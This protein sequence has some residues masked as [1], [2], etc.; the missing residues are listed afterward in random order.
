MTVVAVARWQVPIR[1][2]RE[3]PNRRPINRDLFAEGIRDN[4][5]A[6]LSLRSIPRVTVCVLRRTEQQTFVRLDC[7]S[8]EIRVA[9]SDTNF[10]LATENT[11]VPLQGFTDSAR[12]RLRC[13]YSL[14][15]AATP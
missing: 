2:L 14:S 1:S 5:E 3:R 6:R 10:L 7:T 9:G 8:T 4:V 12:N 11:T 13:V 15:A